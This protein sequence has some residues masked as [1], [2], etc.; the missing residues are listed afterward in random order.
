MANY[1]WISGL[2]VS[3]ILLLLSTPH[4]PNDSKLLVAFNE[5][6]GAYASPR[7]Q[8]VLLLTAHPDDECMFFAPTLLA[9][10]RGRETE[11]TKTVSAFKSERRSDVYSLCL[12]SGDADGLGELR[13]LELERSLDVLGVPQGRRW[14]LDEPFKDNITIFWDAK[15]IA[16]HVRSYVLEH[17]IDI[18]LTFDAHGISSHPNHISLERGTRALLWNAPRKDQ[19][20]RAFSL[21]TTSLLPKYA[22]FAAPL[23]AKL[24]LAL[25]SS[26]FP[27]IPLTPIVKNFVANCSKKDAVFISGFAEYVTALHAMLAHQSQLVWFRWLYV[28]ASRYMWVNEWEEI[29]MESEGTSN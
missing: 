14:V 16:D 18:I 20:L 5:N 28:T 3:I 2:I 6:G 12:S 19:T 27:N 26:P 4:D 1:L 15:V 13:K 7:R 24:E 29:K 9:L 17:E 8:R 22:G 11:K 23:R 25:C 10:T 21:R